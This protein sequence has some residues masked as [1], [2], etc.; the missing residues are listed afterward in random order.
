MKQRKT[1][2]RRPYITIK[3]NCYRGIAS[4]KFVPEKKK[5]LQNQTFFQLLSQ[6]R[7]QSHGKHVTSES[8]EIFD[9][10]FTITY[11]SLSFGPYS[12]KKDSLETSKNLQTYNP[13]PYFSSVEVT[14]HTVMENHINKS[15]HLKI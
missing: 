2:C 11:P 14:L 13:K 8:C 4:F 3:W 10:C 9:K 6:Q 15:V 5:T 7:N 12:C 1:S